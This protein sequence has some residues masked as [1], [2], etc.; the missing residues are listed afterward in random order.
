MLTSVLSPIQIA[1]PDPAPPWGWNPAATFQT[2]F[3][4]AREEQRA[5]QEFQ[6]GMEIEKILLPAKIA[7][8]EY[9]VKKFEMDAQVLERIY[10]NQT[11][12][13]DRSYSGIKSAIGG[14]RGSGASSNVAGNVG[15]SNQAGVY[16]SRFGFGSKL[17]PPAA[18]APQAVQPT[19]RKVGSGLMPKQP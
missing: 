16:Q 4:N 9:D 6:L 5:Q 19:T 1:Q 2:A 18:S 12:A 17:T 10:R 7:K 14:S 15:S 8:A 13:L 11:A 3:N